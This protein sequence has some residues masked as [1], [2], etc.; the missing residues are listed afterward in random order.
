ME[1]LKVECLGAKFEGRDIE[2]STVGHLA[3]HCKHIPEVIAL[4]ETDRCEASRGGEH[5]RK[6]HLSYD[7]VLVF[8]M[9]AISQADSQ[10]TNRESRVKHAPDTQSIWVNVSSICPAL[11][12][13][14]YYET[15]VLERQSKS[16]RAA[17]PEK[18]LPVQFGILPVQF[19]L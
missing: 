17:N 5:T 1:V 12:K 4:Y 10:G 6:R 18:I 2:S 8:E 7:N 11:S 19:G 9:A 14:F 3:A 13:W 16:S 15:P